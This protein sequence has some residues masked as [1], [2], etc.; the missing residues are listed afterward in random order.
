MD[1]GHGH[2]DIKFEQIADA[3]QRASAADIAIVVVGE[4]ALRWNKKRKTSGENIDRTDLQL[5]GIQQELVEAIYAS[6]TPTIVVLVNGR[7]LATEWISDNVPALIE[8][9]EPGCFG[10]KAIAQILYGEVNPSGK[11]AIT[12]PRSVGH[13]VSFYNHKPTNYFRNYTL[14]KTKPLY[15]F[16]YGLNYSNFQYGDLKLSSTSI[17][18]SETIT[19]TIE[20]S[21]NGTV[22]GEEVVQFY[23]N[24]EYASVTRPVKELQGFERIA[25]KAGE[26]KQISFTITP[27][28]MT[29]LDVD[30]KE[31]IEAGTFVAMVGGSSRD[32]DLKKAKFAVK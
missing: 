7:P 26:K 12:I 21:N 1:I 3:K 6:G 11:L 23:L 20:V 18:K 17:D 4:N 27:E 2:K 8:A 32:K 31:V 16:G 10:G 14:S 19:A 25:L 15:E 13:Q 29:F 28:M 22:A 24:D 5:P 30:F 9:W